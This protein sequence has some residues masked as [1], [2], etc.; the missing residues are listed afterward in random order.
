MLLQQIIYCL[1]CIQ[2]KYEEFTHI[3]V[4]ILA[5]IMWLMDT[6][7]YKGIHAVVALFRVLQKQIHIY[8]WHQIFVSI[9]MLKNI[10]IYRKI[11]NSV[12]TLL[13]NVENFWGG[14]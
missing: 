9:V 5:E 13:E 4:I 11:S 3:N 8:L 14:T 2:V 10:K 6:F 7:L 12:G 1:L